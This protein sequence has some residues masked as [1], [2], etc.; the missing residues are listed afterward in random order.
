MS[1]PPPLN[2][3]RTCVQKKVWK[4]S[5]E[6]LCFFSVDMKVYP[7]LSKIP[8]VQ[9][10]VEEGDCLYLPYQWIHS[11]SHCEPAGSCCR[12]LYH[13]VGYCIMLTG[14]V[15]LCY[16]TLVNVAVFLSCLLC[17]C[18]ATVLQSVVCVMLC[19]RK[20]SCFK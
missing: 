13:V 18:H 11:V 10:V 4:G 14:C 8:W 20:Q 16:R 19:Y 17:L 1:A 5:F 9:A 15:E 7:E 12:L 3:L 6:R 2:I